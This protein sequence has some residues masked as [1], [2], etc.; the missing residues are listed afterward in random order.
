VDYEEMNR[1]AVTSPALVFLYYASKSGW[2]NIID[3]AAFTYMGKCKNGVILN[4]VSSDKIN[5]LVDRWRTEISEQWIKVSTQMNFWIVL[6]EDHE[7]ELSLL[8]RAASQNT[9]MVLFVTLLY[10]YVIDLF[11]FFMD[12]ML[13]II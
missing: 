9:D 3:I 10:Y 7:H 4:K 5:R 6:G 2:A 12:S 8:L 1:G 11:S 13:N